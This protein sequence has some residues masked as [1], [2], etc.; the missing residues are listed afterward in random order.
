MLLGFVLGEELF[1]AGNESRV[2]GNRVFSDRHGAGAGPGVNGLRRR[3]NATDAAFAWVW[4]LKKIAAARTAIVLRPR[5]GVERAR[6]WPTWRV[7]FVVIRN[8]KLPRR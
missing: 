4:E 7:A 8:R 1:E 5:P 2:G 3:A 6:C